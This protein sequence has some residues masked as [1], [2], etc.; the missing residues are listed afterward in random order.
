MIFY[1]PSVVCTLACTSFSILFI[2]QFLFLFISFHSWWLIVVA[3]VVGVIVI[4]N[5]LP[6]VL[7]S[8]CHWSYH[9]PV[10]KHLKRHRDIRS[11]K[12]THYTASFLDL[13]SFSR[14]LLSYD[15]FLFPQ[16][17]FFSF[18]LHII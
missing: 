3:G 5:S 10:Q 8:F 13:F 12:H 6:C 17:L 9:F 4:L 16:L 14:Q 7:F 11:I 18:H 2:V 15:F 1:V